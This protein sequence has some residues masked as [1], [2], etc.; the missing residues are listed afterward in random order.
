MPPAGRMAVAAG[1][2]LALLAAT[3]GVTAA[4]DTAQST[5]SAP[6]EISRAPECLGSAAEGRDGG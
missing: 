4:E 1:L 3:F 6:G 5:Q 2:A